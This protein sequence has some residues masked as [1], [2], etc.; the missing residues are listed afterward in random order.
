MKRTTTRTVS[1]NPEV[2]KLYY[3]VT[4]ESKRLV[5][6]LEEITKSGCNCC[7][8]KCKKKIEDRLSELWETSVSIRKTAMEKEKIKVELNRTPG[9]KFDSKVK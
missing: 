8:D 6:R 7:H 9:K 5:K 4:Q 1:K 2:A 3:R